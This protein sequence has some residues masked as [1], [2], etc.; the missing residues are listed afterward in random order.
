MQFEN[1]K[2]YFKIHEKKEGALK[3]GFG[4]TFSQSYR[5]GVLTKDMDLTGKS[6][7]LL[8]CGEG[9]GV[10]F[11]QARGCENIFGFDI[12]DNHIK[13]AKKRYP[14][15]K[16]K[17][18]T[19]SETK[20]IRKYIN[21]TDWIFASGTWNVKTNKKYSKVEEMLGLLDLVNV[22]IATNF[23]SNVEKSDDCHDFSPLI[24]LEMFMD[25]F[26]KWKIDR[27]YFKNDFSI[28]GFVSHKT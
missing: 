18:Y 5:Y 15:L 10:P 9:A 8:G 28:W 26:E 6:A 4:S 22:G 11:L 14:D 21:N 12:I 17:F 16:N 3:L 27:T 24:I 23:T 2:D 25:K 13:S 19:I 1:E 7:I 20:E